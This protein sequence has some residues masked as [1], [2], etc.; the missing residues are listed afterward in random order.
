MIVK[1]TILDIETI[2][3]SNE[4]YDSEC[5]RETTKNLFTLK[6]KKKD[7]KLCNSFDKQINAYELLFIFS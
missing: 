5:V 1:L 6:Q 2:F 7:N 4:S 3:W